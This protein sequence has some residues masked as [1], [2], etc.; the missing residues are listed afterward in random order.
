[1]SADPDVPPPE[2]TELRAAALA[3]LAEAGLVYLPAHLVLS[4]TSG[5]GIGAVAGAIPFVAVFALGVVLVCRFRSSSSTTIVA[6]A[7]AIVAGA[8]LGRTGWA[9]AAVGSI[10]AL[11]VGLRAVTLALRDWREPIHASIGVGTLVLGLETLAAGAVPAW[12]TPLLAFIPVFFVGS[13][14]SRVV[15][16]WAGVGTQEEDP[17]RAS[18]IRRATATM[19]AFGV[20]VA[21]AALLAVRGGV[22]ERIGSRLSPVGNLLLSWFVT[23]VVLVAR[24]ILWLLGVG[25]MDPEAVRRALERWRT[26]LSLRETARATGHAGSS[27]SG[28]LLGLVVFVGIVWLLYRSLRRLRAGVGAFERVDRRSAGAHEVLLAE[29]E[30]PASARLPFRR[31]LPSETVRRWY[32]ETL[33]ALRARGMATEPSLTPAELLPQVA[34]AFPETASAFARLTRMYEDVRYGSRRVSG[35]VVH[36][37]EPELRRILAAIRRPA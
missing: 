36:A 6:G 20:G 31:G 21:V 12:R 7:V 33:L 24:P 1:V 16:V 35:D 17:A 11:L 18:W 27:W 3:A 8:W 34:E 9:E 28:R 5:L 25:G 13:L 22:L 10:V 15:I 14:A 30:A 29:D 2:A 4:D 32:A 26:R 19:L 23:V 37:F